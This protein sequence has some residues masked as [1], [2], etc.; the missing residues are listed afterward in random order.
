M[1]NA[2]FLNVDE[3]LLTGLIANTALHDEFPVFKQADLKIKNTRTCCGNRHSHHSVDMKALK[4]KVKMIGPVKM[5]RL[6]EVL[7]VD[8]LVFFSIGPN[9]VIREEK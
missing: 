4:E 2:R 8:T 3:H 9:G 6:K 7:G 5:K 1:A